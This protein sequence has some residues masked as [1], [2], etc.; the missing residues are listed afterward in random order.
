MRSVRNPTAVNGSLVLQVAPRWSMSGRSGTQKRAPDTANKKYNWPFN[1]QQTYKESIDNVVGMLNKMKAKDTEKKS[2]E[3]ESK[4]DSKKGESGVSNS[5]AFCLPVSTVETT[6]KITHDDFVS[7][8]GYE[9]MTA[10]QIKAELGSDDSDATTTDSEDEMDE[11]EKE[12]IRLMATA[13]SQKWKMRSDVAREEI[14]KLTSPDKNR[15]YQ[16]CW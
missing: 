13:G 9:G 12:R 7:E 3:N 6:A 16:K 11:M 2:E 14:N 1:A 5:G 10:E 15:G 4:Q 8:S